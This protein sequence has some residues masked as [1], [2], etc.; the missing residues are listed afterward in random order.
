MCTPL[1]WHKPGDVKSIHADITIELMSVRSALD[2]GDIE[3][4][5]E[6]LAAVMNRHKRERR[7]YQRLRRW[8][9]RKAGRK[10]LYG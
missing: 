4:A 9:A 3:H 7:M 1:D 2:C 6:H 5:K 8:Y 10:H